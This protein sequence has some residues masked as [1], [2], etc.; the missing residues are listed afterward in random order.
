ML[1]LFLF[2]FVLFCSF[3]F[4]SVLFSGSPSQAALASR[5]DGVTHAAGILTEALEKEKPTV[6]KNSDFSGNFAEG[7]KVSRRAG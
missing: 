5:L 6:G 7:P 3:L 1:V 4:F 2:F